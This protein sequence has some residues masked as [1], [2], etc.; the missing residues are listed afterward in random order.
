[1]KVFFDHQIFLT[2]RVGGISRYFLNLKKALIA[3]D[4][5]EVDNWSFIYRNKYVGREN[6]AIYLRPVS[7]K[8]LDNLVSSSTSL[9]WL[10]R[11]NEVVA[12]ARF[13]GS[14][15]DLVHVTGDNAGYITGSRLNKPVVATVHDLIPELFPSHFPEIKPWLIQRENI[16]KRADHLICISESTKRDLKSIYNI[17][18]EKISMIYHGGPD[19]LENIRPY[20]FGRNIPD[21]KRYVLYVG[22]RKTPY[23]NFTPMVE[24]LANELKAMKDLTLLCVGSP[25]TTA[26]QDFFKKLNIDRLV[27]A[28][29]AHDDELFSIYENAACLILPS[30]Y[31]GF[32]FPLLEAMKAGCPILSSKSSSL[33]EVG[34]K[35]ASYFNPEDFNGFGEALYDLLNRG[36]AAPELAAHQA[37]QL[38]KFSWKKTAEQT[39]TAYDLLLSPGAVYDRP[40]NAVI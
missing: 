40:V 7:F 22:D 38:K 30:L 26:E 6:G 2:Q 16:F 23:K 8:K 39:S 24:R 27:V 4:L 36:K 25:F 37:S 14:D 12:R 10:G 35:A 17:P 28:V 34:G 15:C 32:G 19:Y 11:L 5:S 29:P 21:L 3:N 1:M 20:T 13:K 31:E 9:R 33:P 18:D